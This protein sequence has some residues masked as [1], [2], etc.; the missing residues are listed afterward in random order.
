LPLLRFDFCCVGEPRRLA[1]L[2]RRLFP[3]ARHANTRPYSA[4][5]ISNAASSSYAA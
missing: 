2:D 1:A 4:K 5:I 3:A